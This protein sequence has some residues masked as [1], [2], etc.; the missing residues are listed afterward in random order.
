M[1]VTSIRVNASSTARSA[2]IFIHGLGDSGEGW[3]WFPQIVQQTNL[4]KSYPETNFV[5]PNAPS[6]P[7][8]VNGGF[9]MPA[10]FDIYEFG[11]PHARQDTEGFLKSCN[12]VKQLIN[13][14]IEKY[15]VP[16]ERVIIG[17][18]SQGAAIS[19]ATLALLDVKIGGLV[20]LSGFCPIPQ[21]IAEK[22]SNTGANLNTPVFQG[23]GDIDEIIKF[24]FGKESSEFY[25]SLGFTN[26][27]FHKYPGV[28]H[29]TNNKELVDVIQFISLILD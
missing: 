12:I 28:A 10:W 7:I 21:T 20:A 13:E 26:W 14:Q 19:M 15:N 24:P 25:Q 6:I 5:F 4:V 17:G 11:N 8:S 3:S 29:S 27:K 22:K 23:H 1:S 18:F 2:I 16:A 9:S